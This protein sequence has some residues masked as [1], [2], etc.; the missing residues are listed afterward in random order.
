MEN[1]E[2]DIEKEYEELI[3]NTDL[4][5]LEILAQEFDL[6]KIYE[7]EILFLARDIRRA[8]NEKITAYIHLFETLINPSSPPM[9]VFKILKNMSQEEKDSI[10][11]FYKT[12][13]KTQIEIMKLDTIYSEPSEIAFIEKTYKMWKKLKPEI[14]A[15]FVSF[16]K[17]FE[18]GDI[19][20]ERSYFD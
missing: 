7:K 2:Y 11:I 14:H 10:Q 12:F 20:R 18:N 19:S 6:E 8:V 9:F 3:K 13:S 1:P 5:K 15:L 16:E 4:P 17:N